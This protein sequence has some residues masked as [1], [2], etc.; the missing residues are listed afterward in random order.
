TLCPPTQ[1]C[2]RVFDR[3][4]AHIDL[5]EATLQRGDLLDVFLVFVERGR[6]DT[7]QL[8]AS[9]RRLQHV[10]S[11]DRALSSTG[12]NQRVQLVDKKNDLTLRVFHLFQARLQTIYKFTTVL[13][14]RQHRSQIEPNQ[15]LVAQSF[16]NVARNDSLREAFYDRRFADP[17]LT[18]K[19]RIIF[20][21]TRENLNR[22]PYFIIT[23]DHRIEFALARQIR[24]VARVLGQRL[25]IRFGI[26]IG[27][28][29]AAACLFYRFQQV[30]A[31]DAM[32]TQNLS[33]LTI[34]FICN[35]QQQ[36]L[37]RDV[38]I[39]HLLGA[40]LRGGEDLRQT[41]TEVLLS[42][43]DFRKPADGRFAIVLHNLNVGAQ[44]AQQ[45]SHNA[46]RLFEHRAE[47]MLRFDL[48]ILIALCEFNRG[49]DGFLPAECEFV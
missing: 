27:D 2:N 44:L 30:V 34:F 48:L 49:L 13:C 1:D 20:G 12:A 21:A 9:Q 3:R 45:R 33:G 36:M 24:K 29:R 41:R 43:L 14:V 38:L 6:A 25:I 46:F 23:P 47:K 10:G 35:R 28:A 26:L 16:R 18:D 40:L 17:G 5:L 37:S 11:V 15:T 42:S 7:A 4:L 39:L 19:D 31:A 8:A 22:P 32:L